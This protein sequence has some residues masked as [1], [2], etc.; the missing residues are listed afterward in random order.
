MCRGLPFPLPTVLSSSFPSPELPSCR[1]LVHRCRVR[2][3]PSSDS[4]HTHPHSVPR[5]PDLNG[6]VK[7]VIGSGGPWGKPSGVYLD[8]DDAAPRS[9]FST[10]VLCRYRVDTLIVYECVS[11]VCVGRGS[12]RER[13]RLSL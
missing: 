2:S 13:V 1:V 11:A 5:S 9:G 7:Y 12:R 10:L 6:R 8:S 4:V 3:P